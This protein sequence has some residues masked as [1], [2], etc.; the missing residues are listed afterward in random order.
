M[1]R[2][3]ARDSA[4]VALA[5]L[6][7]TTAMAAATEK[8]IPTVPV[9]SPGAPPVPDATLPPS[10]TDGNRP[11]PP[12]PPDRPP[13]G[14]DVTDGG[15]GP[16]GSDPSP[17]Q[18]QAA[19]AKDN[20]TKACPASNPT[21]RQPVI[22]ATGE[23]I[24]TEVDFVSSGLYGLS[25]SRHY[26]SM[27]ATYGAN[28][29][30]GP[31]WF[32]SLST[33]KLMTA[34]QVNNP[35]WGIIPQ[36]VNL[37]NADGSRE[38]YRLIPSASDPFIYTTGAASGGTLEY[39]PYYG[40]L[41]TKGQ[42]VYFYSDD[43]YLQ[44]VTGPQGQRTQLQYGAP[45]QVSTITNTV[46]QSVIFE[47]SAGHVSA[48]TDPA[49]NRWTYGYDGN[50]MLTSV[51]SPGPNP[52]I[53]TYHY[54]SPVGP[55]FLTGISINGIRHTTYAYY[56]DQRV[57]SSGTTNG[58]ARDTFTYNAG[59]STVTVTDRA[60]QPTTYAYQWTG[61]AYRLI[62]TSQA[63]TSSCASSV[64]SM[65]YDA[66]G[67]VNLTVNRKGTRTEF[68]NDSAGKVL[69][70]IYAAGTSDRLSEVN[71]WA[72]NRL[73]ETTFLD[74]NDQPYRKIQYT[75]VTS[76]GATGELSTVTSLDLIT[77]AS[78]TVSYGYTFHG[79]GALASRSTTTTL[80]GGP[81]T[82]KIEY[83]TLGNPSSA[84]N[85]AGH[86]TYWTLY[87]ALGRPGRFT[88]ANGVS[89][90]YVYDVKGALTQRTLHVPG[91]SRPTTIS[92]NHNRQVTSIQNADGTGAR[93]Q[94]NSAMRPTGVG[95][96][97]DEYVYLD[98]D[99]TNNQEAT[100]SQRWT[101]SLSNQTPVGSWTGGDFWTRS[102][103][104][105]R[106]REWKRLGQNGQ[107][108][109]YGYDANDNLTSITDAAS[110]TQSFSY[111]GRDRLKTSE[112]GDHGVTR[113][114]YNA[115]GLLAIV[116]DP[117]GLTTSYE[118]NG[119]GERTK[120]T[121]PDTG[122]TSFS[123]DVAGRV[124][125]MTRANGAVT[126]FA[127][128]ALG[129]MVSRSSGGVSET[130]SYD[131]RLYGRGRL[132]GFSD[133]SGS[134]AYAYNA[135]GQIAGQDSTVLGQVR[136]LGFGYDWT[137]RLEGMGFPN[138]VVLN[139]TYDGFGRLSQ[140][141][142]NHLGYSSVLVDKFLYQ[143]ATNQRY[144]WRF[145][146]G[147][148]R[149]FTLD[150]D[151]RLSQISSPGVHGL[152]F[153]YHATDTIQ[154]IADSVYAT[155]TS[156][157]AYDAADR[158]T[159][160]TRS[161]DDQ[162]FVLD[163]M[164]NRTSHTRQGATAAHVLDSGSNRLASVSGTKWRN[165]SYDALGNLAS[166][167]RW[168]GSRVYGYDAFN[169]LSSVTVNGVTVAQY[170]NNAL[171]QRV[172]KRTAQGETRYLYAPSGELVYEASPQHTTVH[173]R[174]GGELLGIIRNGQ[175]YASHNDHLGRPEVLTD[176][177]AQVVWRA[178]N[179][180]FDRQVVTDAIG[181]LNVG[182]PGQYRDEETGLWYNWNR[183]YDSM[184]GR[185]TQS[186]PM[187][188]E[189]GI[190]T[191]AYVGGNPVSSIDPTGEFGVPGAIAGGI[192]GGISGGL[193]AAATGGS[194][195]RG[196]LLG[197]AA[198]VFVGGTGA[199][200]GASVL[201]Q[202]ALRAGTGAIGNVLGQMQGIGDPCFTGVN[203]GAIM[204]SALGGA[205]GGVVSPGAWGTRFAGSMGSQVAQR[206]TAGLPGSGLSAVVGLAGN[207]IGAS[208][209]KCG[210]GK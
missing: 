156:A 74:A 68:Q 82:G 175:F 83:D 187:G 131:Q 85:P 173:V 88:D 105:S 109:T 2:R 152:N 55:T 8:P 71:T 80:P 195:V 142:S 189:G 34:G 14:P 108:W 147:L 76:G 177:S 42:T 151:S 132:T 192:I 165:M 65:G 166:E 171:N 38:H 79:S 150:V 3:K 90:D 154:Q 121:S 118:N 40:Y 15:A 193:G 126:T 174:L 143:P 86:T 45:G 13:A 64:A 110:H 204:G 10:V 107:L 103:R 170:V 31:K 206:A 106:M 137:G 138:G 136:G 96:S 119:F 52:D 30:F 149:L 41:L 160:V 198:G 179:A 63:Q 17:S 66:N 70:T 208:D 135:D 47:W 78:R 16:V 26:R 207:R 75:Y 73:S 72:G 161:G 7:S 153:S 146:N 201:G 50:G 39:L 183:Y 184:L 12:L 129:R 169:R 190:N 155:Q 139:Y 89:E 84:T 148:S 203:V 69:K 49:G 94:Y 92:Y 100:R 102:Q 101:P 197:A 210:C 35:D 43:G 140:I 123:H 46:G 196:V 53:R 188:L 4:L 32:S 128:D 194:V 87:D 57:S 182:F 172:Y 98:V 164:G 77:S 20:A 1:N 159:S 200:I 21:T 158:L 9:E 117:R 33:L 58:E 122:V 185:Y 141:T 99:V 115:Q 25:L 22:I 97:A 176:P 104:D 157:F 186:D 127:W 113:L 93:W 95:N 67:F 112:T 124:Q 144:G 130:M 51:T 134:T 116:Q 56:G 181:G 11:P 5:L 125:T 180:A 202:S 162:S 209:A 191:Y 61:D 48:V 6:Q 54:E 120:V 37:W 62:S 29:M 28:G 18:Q 81:I 114:D 178:V 163:A 167:S 168:D 145:S 36:T 23:K 24:K 19:P 111:D 205:M 199:W 133:A 91:A 27:P 44:S 59:N 60:G